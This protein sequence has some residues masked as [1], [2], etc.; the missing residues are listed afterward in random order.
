MAGVRVLYFHV[1]LLEEYMLPT[2]E[3]IAELR[4][5]GYKIANIET[6]KNEN[7][8]YEGLAENWNQGDDIIIVGQD[9]TCTLRQVEDLIVCPEHICS[10]PCRMYPKSTSLPH[11]YLNQ[12]SDGKLHTVDDTREFCTGIVGTGISKISLEV[13][14]KIDIFKTVF[15]FQNFDATLSRLFHKVGY[16]K[17]HLHYPLSEHWKQ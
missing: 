9:N 16:D 8:M 6:P 12:I 1:P 10:I 17:F 7:R 15:H 11:V 4:T 2:L 13:Q 14:K 5:R 3:F